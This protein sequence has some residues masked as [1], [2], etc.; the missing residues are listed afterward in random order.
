MNKRTVFITGGSRGIGKAIVDGL[1]KAGYKVLSPTRQELD[2]S[3]NESIKSYIQTHKN[4]KIDIII[5]NAGINYPQ[6]IQEMTD[7]NIESTLQ[8]NLDAPIRLISGLVSHMKKQKWGRI[9]NMSSAF[10]IVARGKQVLYCAT[11]HGING[12]TKALALEL[13]EYNILVNSVCPGF[14][15]TEMVLRNPKEKIKMIEKDIPLGRL[16]QPNEIAELILFLISNKNTYI[17]G[18]TIV[19]DGGFTSK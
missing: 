2:L 12:L 16:V 17:T 8:I 11:K 14:A 1:K 6:W 5:N 18:S 9:I 15:E 3:K 13:A 7:E 19:I 10:G 4:D